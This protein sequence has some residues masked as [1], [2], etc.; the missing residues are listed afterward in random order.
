M[1]T[2]KRIITRRLRRDEIIL[3]KSMRKEFEDISALRIS[4]GEHLMDMLDDTFNLETPFDF[5][6]D[7][8]SDDFIDIKHSIEI[9]N[10]TI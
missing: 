1:K 2:M 10:S 5:L 8:L 9:N 3:K 4:N 6:E 7:Y